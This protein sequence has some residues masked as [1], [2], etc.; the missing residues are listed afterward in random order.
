MSEPGEGDVTPPPPEG[1]VPALGR[2]A[3]STRNGPYFHNADGAQAFFATKR[4]CNSVGLIHG[5]MLSAFLDGALASAASRGSGQT[6]VTVHLS[7]DFLGM[8]R[9]GEWVIAEAQ[10]TR[11]AGDLAFAEAFA[12]AGDRKLARATGIFKLM[13][14]PSE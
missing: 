4:H 8:G 10:L 2:G 1:F 14:R 7:I 11:R 12:R 13:R 5:G 9:A 3:F 6:L